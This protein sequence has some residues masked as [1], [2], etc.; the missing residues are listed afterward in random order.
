M[1]DVFCTFNCNNCYC[2]IETKGG[3]ILH[4]PYSIN[5]IIGL[6]SILLIILS[7][8][9]ITGCG[10]DDDDNENNENLQGIIDNNSD[11]PNNV[12][13]AGPFTTK[14]DGKDWKADITVATFTNSVLSVT[15][16]AFPGGFETGK[17]EQVG[18]VVQNA[19]GPG[20]Y[21]LGLLSGNSARVA[22][23]E[24]GD[25]ISVTGLSR[26]YAP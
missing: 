21:K 25:A 8:H 1:N 10:N 22:L 6:F 23:A 19:N 14:I 13:N 18:F 17:S 2:K 12:V 15:G 3:A 7:A 24:A 5:R 11:N 26:R 9:V 20:T 4:T 16:Q